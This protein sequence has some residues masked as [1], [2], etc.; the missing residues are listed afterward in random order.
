MAAAK[1]IVAS[2]LVAYSIPSAAEDVLISAPTPAPYQTGAPVAPTPWPTYWP[3][4]VPTYTPT[5]GE[6]LRTSLRCPSSFESFVQIDE[7]ASMQY[8]IV[9]SDDPLESGIFCGRLFVDSS[10]EWVAIAFSEDGNM[11]GSDAIVAVL[12]EESVLKYHLGGR[13]P[14]AVILM[15]D[16]RQTLQDTFVGVYGTMAVVEFTKLLVEEDEVTINGNGL[17]IFLHA[18]GDVWPGYHVSRTV[19]VDVVENERTFAN[20][21]DETRPCP[22]GEYCKLEPG[23]C[24]DALETQVGICVRIHDNCNWP[25]SYLPICGCDGETYGNECEVDESGTSVAYEGHCELAMRQV[26]LSPTNPDLPCPEKQCL[27]PNG[28]CGD[29]VNCFADPCDVQ[30]ECGYEECEANYC[31]GCHHVCT[32]NINGTKFSDDIFCASVWKPVCGDDNNTYSNNCEANKVNVNV[33]YEGECKDIAVFQ[34]EEK[35]SPGGACS[36]E[37]SSCSEGT[38]TCC[39]ETYDSLKCDCF[40]GSWM[41]LQTDACMFPSCCQ[42]G[43]PKDKPAPSMDF[44][45]SGAACDT[46]VDDDYCCNDFTNPGH[47]YCTKSGGMSPEPEDSQPV[48]T[49]APVTTTTTVA[50][51][52]ATTTTTS[53]PPETDSPTPAPSKSTASPTPA[54]TGSPAV[55]LTSSPTA[56]P[57]PYPTEDPTPS[58]TAPPVEAQTTSTEGNTSSTSQTTSTEGTT[59]TTSQ[60]ISS[61]ATSVS[62][63]SSAT[64]SETSSTTPPETTSTTTDSTTTTTVKTTTAPQTT[65]TISPISFMADNPV[66]STTST[67][68]T[69]STLAADSGSESVGATS[70]TTVPST[71]TAFNF[72]LDFSTTTTVSPATTE[73]SGSDLESTTEP[74]Q[75]ATGTVEGRPNASTSAAE[76]SNVSLFSLSSLCLALAASNL[77]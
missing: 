22:D 36:T 8:S 2:T 14:S 33:A 40:G 12:E 64:T 19:F 72:E 4:Y 60:T 41:C 70:S 76:K 67:V 39:G 32:Q 26:D 10:D 45:F 49:E 51:T 6:E 16:D 23:K 52:V 56:P 44:C 34:P 43:P 13:D 37:G 54:P 9:E 38:E 68:Q 3:T 62:T 71:T 30:N 55:A 28:E 11:P 35:C 29:D 50:T 31:G 53:A 20:G 46:E 74:T 42:A 5:P 18:R 75:L 1:F 58:P 24:L 17:N 63:T 65:G 73:E 59:S 27:G 77:M 69:S 66:T 25:V 47:T 61:V 15:E 48:T 57:T 21:C 7:A